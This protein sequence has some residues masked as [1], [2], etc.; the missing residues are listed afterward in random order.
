MGTR[1]GAATSPAFKHLPVAAF[2]SCFQ[3][4]TVKL[5]IC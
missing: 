4:E 1:G 3:L 2:A 5:R